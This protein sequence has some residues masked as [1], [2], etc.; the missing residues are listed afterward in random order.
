MQTNN[1]PTS[2]P[3]IEKLLARIKNAEKSNQKEIKITLAEARDL[4]IDLAMMTGKMSATL[5]SI[6][7]NLQKIAGKDSDIEIKFDGGNF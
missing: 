7:E 4:A 2:M 3:S 1:L 5:K 6:N